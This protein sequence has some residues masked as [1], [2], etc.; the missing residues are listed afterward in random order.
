[1]HC[2]LDSQCLSLI[3]LQHSV[4]KT[5]IA[6]SSK[7]VFGSKKVVGLD[8]W[9]TLKRS[10]ALRWIVKG[11]KAFITCIANTTAFWKCLNGRLPCSNIILLTYHYTTE[12]LGSFW[13]LSHIYNLFLPW[14]KLGIV[15]YLSSSPL[16][17]ST[18]CILHNIR[19]S[20]QRVP[21]QIQGFIILKLCP[22]STDWKN[23]WIRLSKD[24]LLLLLFYTKLLKCGTFFERKL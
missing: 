10:K 7:F 13:S 11:L 20:P 21:F 16:P 14:Y 1:M 4:Y 19:L 8:V 24:R 22:P 2:F 6:Y 23:E 12:C 15:A 18:C 17:K 5:L 3:W 9:Q